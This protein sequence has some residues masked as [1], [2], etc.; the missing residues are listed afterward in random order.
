MSVQVY[1][2]IPIKVY[3]ALEKIL[4]KRKM[5]RYKWIQELIERGVK[6]ENPKT[7]LI[8]EKERESGRDTRKTVKKVY[9]HT[10]KEDQ[11][12][13]SDLTNSFMKTVYPPK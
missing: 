12:M 13:I 4:T 5:T 6:E 9:H 11:K 10:S 7:G 2:K 8:K 1:T 3:L